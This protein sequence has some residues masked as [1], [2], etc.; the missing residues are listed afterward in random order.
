MI[1]KIVKEANAIRKNAA[2]LSILAFAYTY[3]GHYLDKNPSYAHKEI[4]EI[5]F[6]MQQKRGMKFVFVAPRQFGKSTLVTLIYILYCICY[7]RE[8]FIVILS[9]TNK[10]ATD[11]MDNVKKELLG[12]PLIQNDFPEVFEFNGEP[13]PPRWRNNDIETRT[14]IK[15]IAAGINEASRGLRFFQYRPSLVIGDDLEKGD[16]YASVETLE[17]TRESFN[18]TFLP[19]GSAETNFI[20]LGTFFHPYCLLGEYLDKEKHHN[21]IQKIYKALV[22]F[23]TNEKLWQEW[24]NIYNNRQPYDKETGSEAAKKF[25]ILHQSEMDEGGRSLWPEQ[26]SV[27]DLMVEHENNPIVFSS[28]RQNEP[29]DPKTQSFKRD[30]TTFGQIRTRAMKSY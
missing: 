12:N 16:P 1:N 11:I 22:Q 8:K 2:R 29:F 24:S 15:V 3:L 13:K 17:K 27:Y 26:W 25:Y 9:N 5:L 23:P 4:Y 18:K 21:W 7:Q 20:L 10:R 28:E 14:G 30:E 6:E 19:I